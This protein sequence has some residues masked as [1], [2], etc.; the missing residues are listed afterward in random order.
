MII[1]FRQGIIT[2]PT[3]GNLQSFLLRTGE[4]VSFVAD[5]GHVDLAFAHGDSNYLVS[6]S[7]NV[8][9]AW[10]PLTPNVIYWLYWNINTTTGV[11]TFGFTQLVPIVSSTRPS[12]PAEDQHW[13]DL[14]TKKMFVFQQNRWREVIRVFAAKVQNSSFTP[15]GSGFPLKPYAGTQVGIQQENVSVGRIIAD[16]VG[17]P[18]RRVDG[19][20]FTTEDDFFVNGSPVNSVRLE[21][22]IFSVTANTV[23]AKNQVV[24]FSAF[25]TVTEA[26]YNDT[27]TTVI[28][29][30]MEDGGFGDT[31]TVCIQGH[32]TNPAWNWTTVG[33][34]LW[35]ADGGGLT[36]VDPYTV[37]PAIH[38]DG[39]VPVARVLSPTSIVFDQGLGLKGEKGDKGDGA[40]TPGSPGPRGY[41]AYE[42]AMQQGF[43]GTEAQWI[44]SLEGIPGT[45]GTNG[46]SAYQV[47]VQQGFVGTEAQ[48]LTSLQG[49]PGT[50]GTNGTNGLSAYQ[51]AVQQ[52]FVGTEAQW[53]AS[54]QGTPG[55]NGTNGA[56]LDTF[57]GVSLAP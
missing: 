44:A 46:L 15:L 47:A 30:T 31:I 38:P 54:L 36:P 10:G 28:A 2:Y 8:D 1:N 43:V 20:F 5:N 16:N 26:N 4:Y 17:M 13:F 29:I 23:L 27:E 24:K 35:I 57:F 33:A 45:N 18:V 14:S 39:K 21:S 48:W 40:G 7:V 53:L 6:E 32:V 25:N 50:N 37:T 41:S 22:D 3:T 34:P 56:I 9:N 51:V 42:V 55:T 52:G 12:D 49:T 19:R 11:R